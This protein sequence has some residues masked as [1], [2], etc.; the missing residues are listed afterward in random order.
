VLRDAEGQVAF[1]QRALIPV[2]IV[3]EAMPVVHLAFGL[4]VFEL[5]L[6]PLSIDVVIYHL[7]VLGHGLFDEPALHKSF[8]MAPEI[9]HSLWAPIHQTRLAE[10]LVGAIL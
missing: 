2:Q 5:V 6:T 1:P 3:G 10:K 8:G 7:S 9:I 4:Q